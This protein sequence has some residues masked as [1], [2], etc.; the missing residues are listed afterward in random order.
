MEK[1]WVIQQE[2]DQD[3]VL[4]L[5][6]ELGVDRIIA[7]LLAQRG[8]YTFDEAKSF[9]RPQLS[10]LHSP[11]LMKDMDKAVERVLLAMK[12]NERILI[13]GDYDVDGTT[14][15]ALVYTVLKKFFDFID[16]YVP[17]RYSEGYGISK[18]GIDYAEEN[19]ISLVIALDCGIKAIDKIE[20][21]NSKN[22][23]FIICDH[24]TA[25]DELPDACAV[26]DPKRDDC[27]YPCKYL[28]GCGV[29]FKLLQGIFMSLEKD[30]TPLYECLDL[31]AV[32]IA[33]DIVPIIGENRVLAFYGLKQLNE[34]PRHGLK[35]IIDISGAEG[36]LS[37]NDIVFK[38]GPR[39]NAAGRI[40]SGNHAVQLLIAQS[41]EVA[42]LIG[43]NINNMNENRKELDHSITDEALDRIARSKDLLSRKSTVLYDSNWHKGVIG[44]VA[45][46][47]IETYYRP[48]V[49]LTESNGYATGSARSVEGFD[50]YAAISS[51]SDL[52]ENFGGH[53]YAAGLTLKI[54]NIAAFKER[55]EQYVCENITENQLIPQIKVDAVIKLSEINDKFYRILSQFEPFGPQ[56]M[57]PV[58]VSEQVVD[59]G[60]SRPVGKNKEHLKVAVVDDIRE[61]GMKTGIAFSKGHFFTKIANGT[62]FDL[63][64]NLQ[65]NEYMGKREVQLMVKDIKI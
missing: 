52:L 38:I 1:R 12:N 54:E 61:G 40:Q 65:E 37:V 62:A 64:Y 27:Q 59:Y 43:D 29:G 56:N 17:D 16:Y 23:D 28:S 11:F 39:I 50:L 34:N 7:N 51:C 36:N 45:S 4:C 3:K 2:A 33:S 13:Y 48:T 55:F 46:R 14:S 58:F 42:K 20:Y 6:Q 5:M 41:D 30:M 49:I 19:K 25:D 8:I 18:K 21:A 44:I 47:M 63:C 53:K 57:N 60:Y 26:L 32:S 9:F 31:V 15:V 10:D 22:I 24:H 35:T